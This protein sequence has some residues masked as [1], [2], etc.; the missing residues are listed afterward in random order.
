MQM[1]S[2]FA[3]GL[4][5]KLCTQSKDLLFIDFWERRTVYSFWF[6][7]CELCRK[8]ME[9]SNEEKII[10]ASWLNLISFNN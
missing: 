9:K 4:F 1:D 2:F 10:A 7:A 3:A 6:M 8:Y 5:E